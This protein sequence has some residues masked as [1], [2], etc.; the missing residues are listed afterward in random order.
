MGK[1]LCLCILGCGT[2]AQTHAKVLQR[3]SHRVDLYFTSRSLTKAE[4][5]RKR[6]NGR[7]VFGSYEE[8][9]RNSRIDAI[10]ICTPNHLHSSQAY[11]ALNQSKH[12]PIADWRGFHAMW[13]DFL[14]TIQTGTPSLM[15]GLEGA[16][17]VAFV[18]KAYESADTGEAKVLPSLAEL[19]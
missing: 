5:Y 9:C 3:Q 1:K 6:Y 16:R 11:L 2:I 13:M 17:D 19:T 8:A 14:N 7:G 10:L 18:E 4:E 15:T 12:V